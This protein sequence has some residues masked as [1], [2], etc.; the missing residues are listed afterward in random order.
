MDSEASSICFISNIY[1]SY[2]DYLYYLSKY[3]KEQRI[4]KLLEDIKIEIKGLNI[5]LNN[6]NI[7]EITDNILKIINK[8]EKYVNSEYDFFIFTDKRYKLERR[9]KE[10]FNKLKDQQ[11]KESINKIN[12]NLK[13]IVEI[14]E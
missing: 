12:N 1:G 13:E 2:T 6:Q 9:I 11:F 8:M 4:Y 7:K 14:F 5:I 10:L 3:G